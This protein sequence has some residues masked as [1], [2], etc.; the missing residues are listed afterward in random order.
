VLASYQNLVV[1]NM[2]RP[3]NREPEEESPTPLEYW[4]P[5]FVAVGI[6]VIA[7][8]ICV[9]MFKQDTQQ[10]LRTLHCYGILSY[11][12]LVVV[13]GI[14]LEYNPEKKVGN[15]LVKSIEQ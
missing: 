15:W 5:G 4:K 10:L 2:T 9:R 3:P 14:I 7:T 1:W 13:V 12:I 11:I 8:V 6:I